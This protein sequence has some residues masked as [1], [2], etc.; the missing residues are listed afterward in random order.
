MSEVQGV[1]FDRRKWTSDKARQWM[2]QNKY[3]PIKRVHKT[4]NQLRYRIKNPKRFRRFRVKEL[5]KGISLVLGF[6]R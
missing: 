5:G 1:N 6:K 4:A 3:K 2:R